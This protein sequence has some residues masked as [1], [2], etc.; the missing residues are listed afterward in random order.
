MLRCPTDMGNMKL[1][2]RERSAEAGKNLYPIKTR[3]L[4]KVI[5]TRSSANG[6]QADHNG[7]GKKDLSP[8]KELPADRSK[9]GG[10][11]VTRPV[12]ISP[13]VEMK[14]YTIPGTRKLVRVGDS[15]LIQ[16]PRRDELPY[17]ALIENIEKV[18]GGAG[19]GNKEKVAVKVRWFYRPEETI[20]KR[21]PFHGEQ[22]IYLSDHCDTQDAECIQDKCRVH[23][24]KD[25]CK[26]KAVGDLDFYWRFEYMAA[27]Q[28]LRPD[29]VEVFCLC[30]QPENPD[31]FMVQCDLCINWFHPACIGLSKAKVASMKSYVC[32][33][34]SK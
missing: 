24:F 11:G 20:S 27:L 7:D 18:E 31:L 4:S 19:G 8:A 12:N 5:E 26:L 25:Y 17:V 29:A 10:A 16:A 14:T 13:V 30:E 6:Q 21:Q 3:R 33:D 22:E 28:Q 1:G 32:A 2:K 9:G 23:T 34:C 15:V